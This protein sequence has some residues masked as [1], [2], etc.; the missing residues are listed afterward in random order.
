MRA[1]RLAIA[2]IVALLGL[3]WLAQ[4]TGLI[5]GSAMS[6]STFWAIVGAVLLVVAA[7][8]AVREW[9]APDVLTRRRPRGSVRPVAAVE[10]GCCH[11]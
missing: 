5:G 3:V 11:P 7:A 6:G 8:I 10:S 2:L 9:R 4:G 1:S